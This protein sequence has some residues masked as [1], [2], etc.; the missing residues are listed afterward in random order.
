MARKRTVNY[1]KEI[2]SDEDLDELLNH[3]ALISEGAS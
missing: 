1:F 3:K 2:N